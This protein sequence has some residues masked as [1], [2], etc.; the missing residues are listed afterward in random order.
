MQTLGVRLITARFGNCLLLVLTH[1]RL[2]GGVRQGGSDANRKTQNC[3]T[4]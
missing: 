2:G 3:R 4:Y 1:G